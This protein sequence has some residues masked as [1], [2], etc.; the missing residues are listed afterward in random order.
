MTTKSIQQ[1]VAEACDLLGGPSS[2]ARLLEVTP[3]TVSEWRTGKRGV[4]I[5]RCVAIERATAGRVTRQ[6][7]RPDDWQDIWPE[8]ADPEVTK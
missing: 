4:P 7:L 5:E 1:Y 2:L 3:A 8:L 6:A